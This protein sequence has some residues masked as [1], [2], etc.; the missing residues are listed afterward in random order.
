MNDKKRSRTDQIAFLNKLPR[1]VGGQWEIVYVGEWQPGDDSTYAAARVVSCN[2]TRSD[3]YSVH[4][5]IHNDEATNPDGQWFL[6][7]GTYGLTLDQAIQE[8]NHR[9]LLHT[10][11]ELANGWINR[12]HART[13][14][15]Y[16]TVI[17]AQGRC[18]AALLAAL[19]E[20]S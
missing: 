10:L 15:G 4:T 13:E 2:V 5:L 9:P 18:G 3:T 16:G 1:R 12:P 17:A 14:S 19:K 7:S 11:R 20:L 8:A 6:W